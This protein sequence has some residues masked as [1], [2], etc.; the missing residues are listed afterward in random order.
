MTPSTQAA[1]R[2][3]LEA[4]DGLRGLAAVG[5]VILHVW[6]F[7]Q[8]DLGSPDRSTLDTVISQ[9]R[10]GMPLFFVL[11]GFLIFRPFVAAAIEGREG[12]DLRRYVIRRA[13]RIVPAYWVAILIPAALLAMLDHG[14]ARP[15]E[16]LPIYLLF[17][18]NYV[19]VTA[20]GLNPPTWTIAVEVSF[21]IAAPIVAIV[22][23]CVTARIARPQR[24]Q[25]VLAAVCVSC[26]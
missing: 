11:S 2:R 23:A 25:M 8:G 14:E 12:P 15:V 7:H 26:C 1:D 24:R 5:I 22:L 3:R 13:A 18:Q 16:Q 21:Y 17:A 4:L 20:Q 9:L 6:M 19:D 10:L